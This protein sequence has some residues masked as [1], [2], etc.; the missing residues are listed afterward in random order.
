[1]KLTS[2][3]YTA[4]P[5]P[6][7]DDI[8]TIVAEVEEVASVLFSVNTD[9]EI[10]IPFP[11]FDGIPSENDFN[12]LIGRIRLLKRVLYPGLKSPCKKLGGCDAN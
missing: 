5:K 9:G 4:L 11:Y 10:M 1:M 3:P 6:L 12:Q 7:R 8:E 2:Q